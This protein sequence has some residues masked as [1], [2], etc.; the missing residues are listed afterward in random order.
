MEIDFKDIP[1]ADDWE[2]FSRDFLEQFG[3]TVVVPPGRGADGGRDIVVSELGDDSI[4]PPARWLVS[5]KHYAQSDKSVGKSDEPDIV[6]RIKCIGA[7]HFL[8]FYSTVASSSLI[9]RLDEL[10]GH[11]HL[12]EYKILDRGNIGIRLHEESFRRITKHYF[13]A[14]ARTLRPITAL[15]YETHPLPCENCGRDLLKA[16]NDDFELDGLLIRVVEIGTGG[17]TRVID[18]YAVCKGLC[19]RTREAH[20]PVGREVVIWSDELL[21]ASI[22]TGFLVFIR[23]IVADIGLR[24]IEYSDE[25]LQRCWQI[26]TRLAQK[27]LRDSTTEEKD[28]V[29]ILL[30]MG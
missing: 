12:D 29:S 30:Q 26:I 28:F 19:D 23:E 10:K 9:A 11:G 7:T 16:E 22:P 3:F 1:T 27:T 15:F 24:R 18:A 6:D 5:C 25:A 13:P 4:H 8:G 20:Y 14:F 17:K 2:L 21:S